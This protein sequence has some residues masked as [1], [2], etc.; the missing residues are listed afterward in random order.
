MGPQELHHVLLQLLEGLL[1]TGVRLDALGAEVARHDHD[2]VLEVHGAALRIGEAAVVQD[3]QEQVEHVGVRLLDLVEQDHRVRL[4]PD[5]LGELP[6]LLVAHVPGRRPDEPAHGVPLLELA[7]V[8]P[9]HHVLVAEQH[10]GER[11]RQL[12]L[13]DA[14]RPKEQEAPDGA[15]RVP[16]PGPAPANGLGDRLHRLVLPDHPLVQPL[17]ELEQ[18]VALLLGQLRDGDAGRTRDHLGDVLH[19][20]LRRPLAGLLP[21]GQPGL[22]LLRS[23]SA[24]PPWRSPPR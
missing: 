19:R 12:G 9:D 10:L 7:H 21:P 13:A 16:E 3:L 11:A 17:L 14:R 1:P 23:S 22:L 15:L 4:A 24:R 2:G 5:R 8:E 18:P 6:R 20:D